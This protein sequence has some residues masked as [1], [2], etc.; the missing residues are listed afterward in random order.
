[1]IPVAHEEEL[2][3]RYVGSNLTYSTL[4]QQIMDWAQAKGPMSMDVGSWE[5]EAG[6]E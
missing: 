1:M 4:R 2:R 3:L 5:A 6:E